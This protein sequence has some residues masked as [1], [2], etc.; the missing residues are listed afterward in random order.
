[1]SADRKEELLQ[2][3]DRSPFSVK[4][5]LRKLDLPSSTYYR[6]KKKAEGMGKSGLVD[7]SPSKGRTWNQLLD[8]ER[9]QD[10]ASHHVVP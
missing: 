4:D 7:R 5:T 10:P 3:V 2:A 8:E 9:E 1:M 6:W